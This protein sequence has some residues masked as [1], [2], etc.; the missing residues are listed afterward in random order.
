MSRIETA[1]G[2][3]PSGTGELTNAS[4]VMAQ[5]SGRIVPEEDLALVRQMAHSSG[6]FTINQLVDIDVLTSDRAHAAVLNLV[7]AG[8]LSIPLDEL[9]GGDTAVVGRG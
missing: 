3:T 2:S 9:F 4:I 8:E 6:G 1:C 7:A 5:A